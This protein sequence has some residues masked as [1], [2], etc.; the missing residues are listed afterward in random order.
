MP[1][2]WP[3]SH[4]KNRCLSLFQFISSLRTLIMTVLL[5]LF[6]IIQSILVTGSSILNL[7]SKPTLDT[8]KPMLCFILEDC[9]EVKTVSGMGDL[10]DVYTLKRQISE[11]NQKFCKNGC[12]Y[13]RLADFRHSRLNN[14]ICINF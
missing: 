14:F 4:R 8:N 11:N 9:C 3:K 5:F 10:N 1:Y 13:T 12:V 7:A 6:L 2:E